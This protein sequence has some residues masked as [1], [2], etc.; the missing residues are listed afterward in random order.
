MVDTVALRVEAVEQAGSLAGH[1]AVLE[2]LLVAGVE[3][4]L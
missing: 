1:A 4:L 2:L 3:L